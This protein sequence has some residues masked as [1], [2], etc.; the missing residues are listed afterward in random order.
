MNTSLP[1]RKII[2]EIICY[3]YIL[4]FVYAAVSK[5]LDYDNFQLQ[6]GQSPLLSSFAGWLSWF[7]PLLELVL[8]VM[9]L[10]DRARS[11]ALFGSYAL[12]LM[13]STYIFIMLNYSSYTPCSCGG[14]LEKMGWTA[15]LYFNLGFVLLGA[16]AII[17]DP[18]YPNAGP[19]QGKTKYI[20]IAALAV[21]SIISVAALFRWSEDIIHHENPFIRRYLQ[22]CVQMGQ[23][24]LKFNSYYFAGFSE[25]EIY[26]GNSTGPL[27]VTV[28]DSSLTK[29]HDFKMNLDTHGIAFSAPA[30]RVQPPYLYLIDGSVPVIYKGI[31]ASKSAGLQWRGSTQE[32][33]SQPQLID[34][35]TLACRTIDARSQSFELAKLYF[36]TAPKFEIHDRLLEK[37]ADGLF[38]SDGLLQYSRQAKKIVYTHFYHNQL[39]VAR[40]TLDL[41]YRS[42]T[43][44]TT[45]KA[46]IKVAH[47][48]NKGGSKLSSPPAFINKMSAVDADLLFIASA[49][50]G[51]FEDRSMWQHTS[52]I[53]VYDL[54]LNE[55]IASFY[56]YDIDGK[57]L[58]SFAVKNGRLYALIG[59]R[60]VHYRLDERITEHYRSNT[61]IYSAVSGES[62]KPVTE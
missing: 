7:V 52:V 24:D 45:T 13:F 47:M 32:K 19:V 16:V 14:V 6:L 12:M 20:T 35:L 46:K 22:G 58:R 61:K 10:L 54:T 27:H 50:I 2:V 5:L 11:I 4:L 42:H 9:L 30:L 37:Q 44:D 28:V 38:D 56:L 3:S 8:S 43:I 48:G 25:D 36:G 31:L 39:I 53:D 23:L 62:R 57:K 29:K 51:Q 17:I 59:N 55:Y 40:P 34:S 33:F 18:N 1:Y 26:L 60:I 15:H 49:S 41:D 21:T